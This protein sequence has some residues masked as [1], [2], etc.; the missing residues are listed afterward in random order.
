MGQRYLSEQQKMAGVLT[1]AISS[2]ESGRITDV[3]IGL[4]NFSN[5]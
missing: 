1:E 5:Q 3:I 2:I 4:G